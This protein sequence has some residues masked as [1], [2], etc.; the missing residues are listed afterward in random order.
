[1][2]FTKRELENDETEIL[3]RNYNLCHSPS[4]VEDPSTDVILIR[5]VC[6]ENPSSPSVES[7]L[8]YQA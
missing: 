6:G 2:P 7:S 4:Y 8:S 1:M 5:D 3:S